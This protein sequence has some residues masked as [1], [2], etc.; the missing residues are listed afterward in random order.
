MNEENLKHILEKMS[1]AD[2]PLNAAMI[3]ERVSRNFD[4]AFKITQPKQ[5]YLMPVR[6]IAAAAVIFIV[7]A[8]GRWS[9]LVP[10]M[11]TLYEAAYTQ[12]NAINQPVEKNADSFWQQKAIAA[13]QSSSNAQT[14][15]SY[16]EKLNAY[17]QYL[18]SKTF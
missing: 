9:K 4:T 1:R 3:A 5:W 15:I 8:A 2:I 13:M 10:Q 6:F 7:F 14:S 12:T 18:K 16:T 11:S 17:K